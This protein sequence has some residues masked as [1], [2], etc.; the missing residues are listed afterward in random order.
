MNFLCKP[1]V[2]L[3]NWIVMLF[4]SICMSNLHIKD[5]KCVTCWKK[6]NPIR[7]VNTKLLNVKIYNLKLPYIKHKLRILIFINIAQ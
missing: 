5:I 2:L 3:P 6:I 1:F 4:F 7:N